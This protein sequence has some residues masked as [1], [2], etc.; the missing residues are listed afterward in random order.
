MTNWKKM[1][2]SATWF[3]CIVVNYIAILER[4]RMDQFAYLFV[5][6]AIGD[7]DLTGRLVLYL[8]LPP[9]RLLLALGV[10][11]NFL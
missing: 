9:Y 3:S 7:T 5:V 2:G 1:L 6:L 10:M 11:G 4:K 8:L